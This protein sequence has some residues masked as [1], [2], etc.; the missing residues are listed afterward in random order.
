[1]LFFLIIKLLNLDPNIALATAEN[2]CNQTRYKEAIEWYD[3]FLHIKPN[4]A[5]ALMNKGLALDNM[6][7][8]KEAI[9]LYDKAL[10]IE[11]DSAE[12]WYCKGLSI[13]KLHGANKFGKIFSKVL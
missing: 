10:E 4:D 5:I 6:Q 1:M 11:P 13:D 3:K 8:F 7:K 12:A 2:L 9:E